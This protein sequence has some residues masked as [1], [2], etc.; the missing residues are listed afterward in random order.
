MYLEKPTLKKECQKVAE[1]YSLDVE[2][3]KELWKQEFE[4]QIPWPFVSM[5]EKFAIS[6]EFI[7]EFRHKID[8]KFL[9]SCRQLSEIFL[10]RHQKYL[11]WTM[12]S[13][14]QR[15][16]QR[17]IEKYKDKLDWHLIKN[18]NRFVNLKKDFIK[19]MDK[20]KGG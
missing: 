15:I 8:W 20:Y 14:Y 19:K 6:K 13:K 12:V 10:E 9:L 11:C 5:C 4:D 7:H 1:L 2:W 3:T 18:V 17:F 16:S